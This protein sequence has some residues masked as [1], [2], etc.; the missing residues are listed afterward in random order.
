MISFLKKKFNT[1]TKYEVFFDETP[2][3]EEKKEEKKEGNNSQ[4]LINKILE[5]HNQINIIK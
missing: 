4:K 1:P 2:K 5:N 3:K